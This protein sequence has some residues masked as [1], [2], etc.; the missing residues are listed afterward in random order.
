MPASSSPPPAPSPELYDLPGQPGLLHETWPALDLIRPCCDSFV[1]SFKVWN[2]S[3]VGG[4]LCT[5]LPAGP[6]ISLCAG[7]DGTATILGPGGASRGAGDRIRHGRREELPGTRRAPAQH[8]PPG[9]GPCLPGGVPPAV[10]EQPRQVRGAADRKA[11]RRHVLCPH[12]HRRHQTAGAA[13]L[14]RAA[15]HRRSWPRH[16]TRRSPP[17][18]TTTTSTA[19][20]CGAG[21]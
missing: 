9:V 20:L 14:R 1:A 8:Q 21:I 10:A 7:L 5:S 3:T 12:R 6:I 18:F 11:R 4:N 15:G 19:C 13:A 17:T 16:S 2:M